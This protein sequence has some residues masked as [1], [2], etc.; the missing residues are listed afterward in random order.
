[1]KKF[2]RVVVAALALAMTVTTLA[3]CKTASQ[4]NTSGSVIPTETVTL[5]VYSQ[6]AN[7]S[8]IQD[9]WF[10]ALMLNKFNVKLNIIN[11]TGNTYTTRMEAGDLGDLAVWGSTGQQYLDAVSQGMLLAWDD[12]LLASHGQYI[13]DN[14]QAALTQNASI[15]GT[16][17]TYGFGHNVATNPEDHEA[18]FYSWDLRYD[19]YEELGCPE[20]KDLNDLMDVLED[21]KKAHPTDDN[22][23]ETYAISLWPDWD[24]TMVMYPKAL[25][26]AY[27]GYDELGIGHYNNETG[28][29]YDALHVNDDGSYGPYLEMLQFF[30]KLYQK[31]LLDPD[32]MTQTYADATAT[33]KSGRTFWS[34]F[35]YAGSSVFNTEE[36]IAANKAMYAVCPTDATPCAYGMNVLGGNRVWTIGSKTKYPELCMEILNYL[37]TPEG[38]L[39][40]T[41][42]PEGLCWEIGEDGLTHFTDL[43]YSCATNGDTMMESSDSEYESYTGKKFKDGQQQ[44]NN[45]T[46]S[47]DATNPVTGEKYNWKYWAST[48]TTP[49]SGSIEAEWRDWSGATSTDNYLEIREGGGKYSVAIASS[50]AE[51]TK[52]ADLDVVWTQVT[53]AIVSGSW[54]AIYA[55]SDADFDKEVQKLIKDANAYDNGNGYQECV[56]WS[57]EQAAARKAAEDDV[58]GK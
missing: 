56:D 8:G 22:G 15:S 32:S 5:N 30:N 18:F 3:A 33:I 58:S 45:T 49:A 27:Y 16:G 6:L 17:S 38:V 51:G 20:M 46:W 47:V 39:D 9:G 19:Y 44:I 55:K 43:G 48:A 23:L 13:K 14:M 40:S 12:T 21:M 42:G 2:R 36:N 4:K 41:Y 53:K 28:E 29:F 11:E 57:K 35:N 24:G 31:G 26:T 10:A 50:Y 54:N 34:I 52:S 1:M 7:Y 37:C 25:V